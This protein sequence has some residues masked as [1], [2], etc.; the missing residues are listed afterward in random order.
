VDGDVE[1]GIAPHFSGVDGEIEGDSG[2]LVVVDIE[3]QIGLFPIIASI[4]KIGRESLLPETRLEGG[5]S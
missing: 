1:V 2:E 5:L 4:N 3:R